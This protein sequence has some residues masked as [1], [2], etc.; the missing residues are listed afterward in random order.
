MTSINVT[1]HFIYKRKAEET[2]CQRPGTLHLRSTFIFLPNVRIVSPITV[3]SRSPVKAEGIAARVR[4]FDTVMEIGCKERDMLHSSQVDGAATAARNRLRQ[5]REISEGGLRY[6]QPNRLPR[7][8][9]KGSTDMKFD[10]HDPCQ[11]TPHQ[12]RPGKSLF[13]KTFPSVKRFLP[14]RP[15]H[16]HTS[17]CSFYPSHARPSMAT[18]KINSDK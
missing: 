9:P 10:N 13:P 12:Q 11:V 15:Q 18:G 17:S 4:N 7:V 8:P 3:T 16:R 2:Q 1:S 14:L 6:G 5:S